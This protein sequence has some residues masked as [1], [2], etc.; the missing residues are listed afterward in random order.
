MLLP[1]DG[2]FSTFGEPIHGLISFDHR[3][4]GRA[5]VCDAWLYKVGKNILQADA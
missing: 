2:F 5:E 4:T 1:L 3:K